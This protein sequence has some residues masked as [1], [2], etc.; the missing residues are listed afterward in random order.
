MTEIKIPQIELPQIDIPETPFF[1]QYKLEGKIPGCNYYHRDLETTRNP[2]LLLSDHNGTFI[3][4][5]DGEIPSYTPMRYDPNEIIY[6]DEKAPKFQRPKSETT[7][8]T[9]F[10]PK[11]E[12]KIEYVPCPSSKDQRINDFRN[13]SRIERV[14]G[15]K[16]SEDGSEC[17]T[18]YEAVPFKDQYIPEVSSIVSTAVFGLVAA[19]SP[20]LLNIIKPAIKNLVKRLTKKKDKVK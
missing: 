8:Q 5:P 17:I 20:L 12:E 16:L 9:N 10:K 15:H 19:S 14:I 4:C 2:S 18:L 3:T 11:E 1:I 13:S 7:N 6:V